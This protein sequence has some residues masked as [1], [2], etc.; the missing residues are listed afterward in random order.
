MLKGLFGKSKR[1]APRAPDNCVVYAIGDIH[2]R[3]DLLEPLLGAIRQDFGSS[4][5]ARRVV[6]FLGDYVDRG[7]DS[8]R[9]LDRLLAFAS[10][11]VAETHFIRG[12]HEESFLAFMSEPE[13]GPAWCEFGGRETLWSYG[14]TPPPP[15]ADP[16]AWAVAAEAMR[17]A[18][19]AE[20]LALLSGL[21]PCVE[22]GDYFFTHA[23]ARPGVALSDQS[24][25]D[26]MWIRGDFLQ[27][28]NRFERTVVHG[29]TPEPAVHADQRRIGI[30][31]GAYATG[32]LTAL[33]L[34]G[35]TADLLQTQVAAGVVT[36]R[37]VA[38]HAV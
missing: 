17:R 18:L 28:R 37:K 7:P 9:V 27:A 24:H 13:T 12:N 14:V 8:K 25:R 31:T 32:V 35:A 1:L 6:I 5:A 26:L 33:R 10:A 36:V 16:Q 15:R 3:A 4:G 11:A 21:E 38:L 20:H 34:E 23:G 30:D 29:H 2:G 22:V 19:P